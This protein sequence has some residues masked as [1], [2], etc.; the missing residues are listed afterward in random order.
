MMLRGYQMA[1]PTGAIPSRQWVAAQKRR[2]RMMIIMA[3]I[4]KSGPMSRFGVPCLRN[5]SKMPKAAKPSQRR[6][7]TVTAPNSGFSIMS[8]TSRWCAKWRDLIP[9]P[10]A[11]SYWKPEN[12][13]M[14][15]TLAPYRLPA[16]NLAP[17]GGQ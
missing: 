11:E 12:A 8:M 13:G 17:R 15:G 4:A 10:R 14:R 16:P 3:K 5:R 6:F 7:I 9:K 2:T 1:E